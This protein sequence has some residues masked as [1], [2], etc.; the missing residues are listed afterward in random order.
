MQVENLA[1]FRYEMMQKGYVNKTELAKFVGC[2]RNSASVVYKSIMTDIKKEGLE[3]IYPN[4]VLTKRVIRYLGLTEKQIIEAYERS[5]K[6][7]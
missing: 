4:V 7:G 5:I 2:G 6:K 3:S 1:A